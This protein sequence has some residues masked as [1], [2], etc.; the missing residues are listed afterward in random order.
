MAVGLPNS[1]TVS[2]KFKGDYNNTGAVTYN[3][4]DIV[5]VGNTHWKAKKTVVGDGSSISL[6][7]LDW[8]PAYLIEVDNV[9]GTASV[10]TNQGMVILYI[11]DDNGDYAFLNSFVSP[12]PTTN[13]YFGSKIKIAKK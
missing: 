4:G 10:L 8:E 3:A 7:S 5:R 1:S 12:E 11:R 9:A 13:E 2:T 6:N